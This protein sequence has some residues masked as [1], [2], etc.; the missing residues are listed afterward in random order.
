MP[1][2][3]SFPIFIHIFAKIIHFCIFCS[4]C[5]QWREHIF[6]K[7]LPKIRHKVSKFPVEDDRDYAKFVKVYIINN[8]LTGCYQL[9]YPIAV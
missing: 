1:E 8:F 4:L 7:I 3:V 9:L 2:G 5:S 6:C